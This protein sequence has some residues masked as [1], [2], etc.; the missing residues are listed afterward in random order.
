LYTVGCIVV[1]LFL[2]CCAAPPPPRKEL[3]SQTFT[4]IALISPADI[5]IVTSGD[6]R[7]DKLKE[8]IGTG[9][10]TGSL[11]GMLV[12]AAACGPYLYGL[13]VIGLGAAGFIAGGTGGAIYGFSGVSGS[14]ADGLQKKVE[15]LDREKDLQAQ[16]VTHVKALLP[17]EMLTE[18][19]VAEIQAILVI[20][21]VKF[22]KMKDEV[23]LEVLVRLT[24]ATNESRRVPELG[25]RIFT[26]RSLPADIDDWLDEGSNKLELAIEGSLYEITG[27][28]ASTLTEHWLPSMATNLSGPFPSG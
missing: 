27:I 19:E 11:G 18:P 14:A 15:D 1:V 7:S 2:T 12:G 22:H 21:N 8:G 20:E 10:A 23:Y 3:G 28:I 16:L 5:I 26:A 17:D 9:A 13:C 4:S 25:S 24:F 6:T